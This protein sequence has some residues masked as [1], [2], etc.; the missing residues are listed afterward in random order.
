MRYIFLVISFCLSTALLWGQ[1]APKYSNEFLNIGAGSRALAMGGAVAASEDG[2]NTIYYNPAGITS[3]TKDLE[4]GFMHAEYFAGVAS[5]DYY[6]LAYNIDNKN[7]LS[8]AMVRF[9]V[10]DIPNTLDL[11]DN[12]GNIRYDRLSSF[13]AADMAFFLSYARKLNNE[14]ISIGGNVKVIRR[15]AGDFGNAWGFGFD[16]S[17]R[18]KHQQW[19]FAATLKDVT[20]TFNAWT[21][22]H[23][24]LREAWGETNNILPENSLELTLPSLTLAVAR[25]IP[26]Y[27]KFSALV[28]CD[29][30]NTFDGKRNTLLKTD[31]ISV[32]PRIGVELD[33]NKVVFLRVGINNF[34]EIP[35]LEDTSYRMQLNLGGGLSFRGLS[36]DYT[37]SNISS[38]IN[39]YSHIFSLKYRFNKKATEQN[40]PLLDS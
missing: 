7:Y 21:F 22:N 28:E 20:S 39:F 15:V 35:L 19:F 17:A 37:M 11:I 33:Y 32:D 8:A 31:F 29:L 34:Q 24:L 1:S 13:S 5:Y 25:N 16:F 3:L 18:A 6:S 14:N 4:L 27:Q 10:D 2:A 30:F 23:D 26:I 36:I 12:D 38:D 9:G 40:K